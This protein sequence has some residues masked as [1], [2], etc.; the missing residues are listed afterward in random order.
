MDQPDFNCRACGAATNGSKPYCKDHIR[1]M[2]YV[3]TMRHLQPR[4]EGTRMRAPTDEEI[5]RAAA[6]LPPG[7]AARRIKRLAEKMATEHEG[8]DFVTRALRILKEEN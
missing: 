3:R 6:A 7:E 1:R 4:T 8:D 5:R 2:E